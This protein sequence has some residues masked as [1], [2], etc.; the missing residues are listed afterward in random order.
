MLNVNQ[1]RQQLSKFVEGSAPTREDVVAYATL[2]ALVE[3][4]PSRATTTDAALLRKS[5]KILDQEPDRFY[6]QRR[7]ALVRLS[8]VSK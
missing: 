3:H 2:C 1:A 7:I 6:K 8:E 5:A 4:F